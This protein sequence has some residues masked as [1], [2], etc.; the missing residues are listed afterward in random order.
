MPIKTNREYRSAEVFQPTEEKEFR[1]KGYAS[2]FKPYLL[3]KDPDGTEL[4][5]RIVPTAFDNADMS[6]VIFQRDH[7]GEVYARQS[8]GT[9]AVSTDEHGLYIEADLGKTA[10][11]RSMYEAITAGMYTQMSFAFTVKAD[12]YERET[13]TRVIDAIEKVYDVSAVSIP[14]NPDTEISARSYFE[15]VIEAEKRE[16]LEAEKKERQKRIIKILTLIGD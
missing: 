10:N 14:A 11:A 12:H 3:W 8:N 16:S 7:S 9:L 2:T 13:R 5:E 1:V 6:D 15:G 4:Y